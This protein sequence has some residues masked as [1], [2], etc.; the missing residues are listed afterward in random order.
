M[1]MECFSGRFG[2]GVHPHPHPTL[3]KSPCPHILHPHPCCPHT[4]YA[5]TPCPHP[6]PA[7]VHAGIHTLPSC[8]TFPQLCL[9]TL[10]INEVHRIIYIS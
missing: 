3:F 5:N 4:S 10:I 2:G 6:H 7:Q 9:M 8:I 1:G